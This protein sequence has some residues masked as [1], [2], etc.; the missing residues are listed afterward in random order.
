MDPMGRNFHHGSLFSTI[1]FIE[2]ETLL[3]ILLGIPKF[4]ARGR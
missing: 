2:E 4:N 1:K 3:H